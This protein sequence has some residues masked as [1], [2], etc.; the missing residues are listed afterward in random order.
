MFVCASAHVCSGSPSHLGSKD[1]EK[2]N[3]YFCWSPILTPKFRSI[4]ADLSR[5]TRGRMWH[6]CCGSCGCGWIC[7]RT[8]RRPAGKGWSGLTRLGTRA[9]TPPFR[10]QLIFHGAEAQ[11]WWVPWIVFGVVGGEWHCVWKTTGRVQPQASV[12]LLLEIRHLSNALFPQVRRRPGLPQDTRTQ[13]RLMLQAI[14]PTLHV[15]DTQSCHCA[16]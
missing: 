3:H 14:Q 8:Q 11:A 15:C 10:S 2:A 6:R 9:L 5:A 13:V 12:S 7:W 1:A 4:T 16:T